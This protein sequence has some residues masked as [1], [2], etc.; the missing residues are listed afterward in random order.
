MV[1]VGVD[2]DGLGFLEGGSV[3]YGH[4]IVVHHG[5]VAAGVRSVYLAVIV[6]EALGVGAYGRGAHGIGLGIDLA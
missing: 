2:G 3:H 1:G 5:D 4:C 6:G